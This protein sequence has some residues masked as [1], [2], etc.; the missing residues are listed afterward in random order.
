MTP[1]Q[2][3]VLIEAAVKRTVKRYRKTLELLAR[4]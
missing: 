1:P 3:K 4:T 2:K